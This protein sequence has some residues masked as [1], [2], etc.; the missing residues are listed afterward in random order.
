PPFP[1]TTLFRSQAINTA[2]VDVITQSLALR[3]CRFHIGQLVVGRLLAAITMQRIYMI[4]GDNS[5]SKS[6]PV[7]QQHLKNTCRCSQRGKCAGM[8]LTLDRKSTRLNSS[9]V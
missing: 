4:V 3:V 5:T 9:H 7:I 8:Y 6:N 2:V 1:Y